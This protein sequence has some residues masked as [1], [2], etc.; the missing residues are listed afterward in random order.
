MVVIVGEIIR[1]EEVIKDKKYDYGIRFTKVPQ[2]DGD[3]LKEFIS[4]YSSEN[5]DEK[6]FMDKKRKFLFHFFSESGMSHVDKDRGWFK[7]P[8]V[9][10]RKILE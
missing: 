3:A 5:K 8:K 4:R 9:R 7:I 2:K 1:V 10:K 6:G